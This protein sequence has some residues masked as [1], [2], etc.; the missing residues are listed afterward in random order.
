[1]ATSIATP[2]KPASRRAARARAVGD[3]WLL[4]R[5]NLA[6]LLALLRY[7]LTVAPLVR[8][9]LRHWEQRARMIDDPDL[10]ARAREKLGEE[11]F[12]AEV[13]AMLAT[14][15]PRRHRASAVT[16]IVTLEILY[17]YLDGLSE[18]PSQHALRDGQQLL[19]AF[20]DA[21]SPTAQPACD[22]YPH[23]P[24]A[25]DNGYLE[26]LVATS[27]GALARLPAIDVIS[28]VAQRSAARGVD[29]QA[30]IHAA[31]DRQSWQLEQWARLGAAGTALQWREWLGGSAA[32]VLAVHALI[33]AAT[34][35]RMTRE[36]AVQIDSAYLS[37]CALSTMLDSLIDYEHD[38][39]AGEPGFIRHYGGHDVFADQLEH[40]A[41]QAAAEVRALPNDAYHLM[42]L[43]GVVA[44]Y[45]SA[46]TATRG[47]A[48]PVS[49]R[50]RRQLQPLITPTLVIMR[51]WRIARQMQQWWRV[52]NA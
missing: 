50:I 22:Y 5:A 10:R 23:H 9:Q 3:R 32:S 2:S 45:I 17:D 26:E 16:A 1:M 49:S 44:Y 36:Q 7:R 25:A 47:L 40:V 39:D 46:P 4:V 48:A 29:A 27:R 11:S 51:V 14:L 31:C 12:N 38:M 8:A 35:H 28:D 21:L 19:R 52:R 42:I 18:A 33:V 15:A 41:R 30:R 24:H 13:A 37:I 6:L 20:T 43:I 34:D